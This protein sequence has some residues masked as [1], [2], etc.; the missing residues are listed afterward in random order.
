MQPR[1][2]CQRED[3]SVLVE[4][5][6]GGLERENSHRIAR[7]WRVLSVDERLAMQ[8]ARRAVIGRADDGAD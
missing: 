5:A 3:G 4:L 1:A 6:R 8:D 2:V 7:K